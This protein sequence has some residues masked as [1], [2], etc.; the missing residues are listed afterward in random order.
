MDD[1]H[2]IGDEKV[3]TD[4]EEQEGEATLGQEAKVASKEPE[5]VVFNPSDGVPFDH[6][7]LR[8]RLWV[9][10]SLELR[11]GADGVAVMIAILPCSCPGEN[12]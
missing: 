11:G 12:T 4:A 8:G 2:A 5:S 3:D 1:Q 10:A 7:A 9:A 6:Q